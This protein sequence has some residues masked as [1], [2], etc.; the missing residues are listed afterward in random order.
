MLSEPAST[1]SLASQLGV[2]PSAVSQHLH[3]LASAGLATS[4]RA[5]RTVLYQQTAEGADLARHTGI[6]RQEVP[7][8]GPGPETCGA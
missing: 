6:T 4:A 7:A 2:T 1:A 3:A 8:A 5:G